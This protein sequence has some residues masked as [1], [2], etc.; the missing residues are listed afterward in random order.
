MFQI[1]RRSRNILLACGAVAA[2]GYMTYRIYHPRKK[3]RIVLFLQSFSSLLEALSQ[4]SSTFAAVLSD[5]H[6]FLVSEEDEV[7]QTLKQLLKVAASREAQESIT[8]LSAAVSRGLLSTLISSAPVAVSLKHEVQPRRLHRPQST[9]T[10]PSGR[11][12]SEETK[13][14][15]KWD[16]KGTVTSQGESG[17]ASTSFDDR[18]LSPGECNENAEEI[19]I[20]CEEELYD[21]AWTNAGNV[22][23][24]AKTQVDSSIVKGV[25]ETL[26][27]EA[28]ISPNFSDNE[29]ETRSS[30]R[31][32]KED[33]VDRL[34]QKLFSESGKSFV[35][36]VVASASRSFVAS[37]VE[38]FNAFNNLP[39][40]EG[41]GSGDGL[42][43]GL[44]EFA[45]SP[46]GKPLL[47]DWIQTFVG[48]AVSVYLDRTKDI[49]A[50][51]EFA[52][53]LAKPEH[54][55]PITELL[56]TICNVSTGN[57]VRTSH[58][59]LTSDPSSSK[60]NAGDKVSVSY[61]QL[62]D[63]SHENEDS[64]V[65]YDTGE[66]ELIS[67][68][69]SLVKWKG[70]SVGRTRET[71]SPNYIEHIS[72][73]IAVPS[74]RE[75]ILNIVGTMTSSGVRTM[76]DVSLDKVS[77]ILSG[78]DKEQDLKDQDHEMPGRLGVGE[79]LQVVGDVTKAA[80]DKA[81]VLMTMC[82]AVCLHSVVGGV[83]MIKPL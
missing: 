2:G 30:K 20:E 63:R 58:E 70:K 46:N 19:S 1:S 69:H 6:R 68:S 74:N 77:A 82:Y 21:H 54:Q 24:A 3:L 33:I 62:G 64:E 55:G 41:I 9:L 72:K 34:I 75:L 29:V 27:E 11:G 76:I 4:G 18:T 50:F 13:S 39:G 78:K 51:D 35:S 61:P 12:V 38:Q 40:N 37:V 42:V 8:A 32:G 83:R 66:Q 53:T 79:K 65:F 47:T 52:A 45:N 36:I 5:L 71:F 15:I 48:T 44:L 43:K 14:V 80:I 17:A 56:T 81:M 67:P 16:G 59:I 10:S 73:V 57:F 22:F 7:P 25:K 49:N 26:Q 28:G 31:S 23:D 60:H